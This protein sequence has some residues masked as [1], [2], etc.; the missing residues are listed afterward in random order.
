MAQGTRTSS[1]RL[2]VDSDL[3]VPQSLLQHR[4]GEQTT[5]TRTLSDE[6]HPLR[7]HPL[8]LRIDVARNDTRNT[9]NQ[10]ARMT[11]TAADNGGPGGLGRSTS[12][13][14][15]EAKST[16]SEAHPIRDPG[17]SS[18][19][20]VQNLDKTPPVHE[21]VER[22]QA[23]PWK[24]VEGAISSVAAQ[25]GSQQPISRTRS[26]HTDFV[27][28]STSTAVPE[29]QT[30]VY[31]IKQGRSYAI[32]HRLE[33]GLRDAVSSALPFR[34]SQRSVYKSLASLSPDNLAAL[35][36]VF[37]DGG[38]GPQ[39]R[40][41]VHL[42]I[43]QDTTYLFGGSKEPAIIAVVE[44]PDPHRPWRE[45]RA[46]IRA[47][48]DHFT[49]EPTQPRPVENEDRLHEIQRDI[50]LYSNAYT[51]TNSR[52]RLVKRRPHRD[53]Q[54]VSKDMMSR[55]DYQ[56][57]LTTYRV[58]IIQQHPSLKQSEP[59]QQSWAKCAVTEDVRSHDDVIQSLQK[60]D[61]KPPSVS[62]KRLSLRPDQQ[63]Q[64]SRLHESVVDDETHPDYQ[65]GLR[66]L[67]IVC[68]K[69]KLF[70]RGVP[71]ITAIC[72][73][74]AR[75]PRAHANLQLLYEAQQ[76]P[77]G[78]GTQTHRPSANDPQPLS[79]TKPASL[80]RFN[81]NNPFMVEPLYHSQFPM[82]PPPPA[83][84]PFGTRPPLP[85]DAPHNPYGPPDGF[86]PP[87]PPPPRS[88]RHKSRRGMSVPPHHR[89]HESAMSS[90]QSTFTNDWSDS[91]YPDWSS[92]YTSIKGTRSSTG[93]SEKHKTR[94]PAH[95]VSKKVLL[96]LGYPW[97]E[98]VSCHTIYQ[99]PLQ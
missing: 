72:V 36:A 80:A 4:A 98:E 43:L 46:S 10:P 54:D 28:E 84:T 47:R 11:A 29:A 42:N 63:T 26:L 39:T 95:L 64:I 81:T 88:M 14:R 19:V 87:V 18:E 60:L 58:W 21:P 49:G 2:A 3:S 15:R 71:S 41:L 52:K 53:T 62:H 70:Q 6:V 66:Q 93:H 38:S 25:L 33:P 22:S 23:K 90:K 37:D 57:A 17:I 56:T 79:G 40:R 96:D 35:Q 99:G 77:E 78:R 45:D 5:A 12:R 30:C 83:P 20:R 16:E 48:Q 74:F 82:R 51:D 94:L 89:R 1:P 67:D 91:D 85:P 44:D 86:P 13:S 59:D 55:N 9:E 76:M 50:R 34:Q 24:G 75:A 61:S 27:S 7:S 32:P 8:P 73:Y 65:W 31:I 68:P 92:L 69:P 97:L